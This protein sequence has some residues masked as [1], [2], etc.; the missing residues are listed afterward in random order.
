MGHNG[1]RTQHSLCE[2]VGSIPCLAHWDKNLALLQA[3]TWVANVARIQCC[4]GYGIAS[5]AALIQPL[6]WEL[7][8]AICVAVKRKKYMVSFLRSLSNVQRPL[9]LYRYGFL[10]NRLHLQC[11]HQKSLMF[12]CF[13]IHT[14]FSIGD[15]SF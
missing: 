8:Y 13:V 5:A 9:E 10:M 4:C 3:A 15:T 12:F 14:G 7:P 6:A 1:L 2:D 11:K